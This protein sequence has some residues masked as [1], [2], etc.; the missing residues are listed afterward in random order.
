MLT[1]QTLPNSKRGT[2]RRAT[3]GP[4]VPITSARQ[5]P[6]QTTLD[7]ARIAVRGS[8]LG[9]DLSSQTLE[10]ARRSAEAKYLKNIRFEQLDTQSHR[11]DADLFDV[12]IS[13]AG[14]MFFG[15]PDAAFTNIAHA[16]RP[17]GRL[18]LLVWQPLAEN[19]WIRE[20]RAAFAVGR[21]LPMPPPDAPG[22]FSLSDPMRVEQ[23]LCAAGFTKPQFE[24]IAEPMSFGNDVDG[25]FD[26]ICGM[27]GWMLDNLVPDDRDRALANLRTTLGNHQSDNGVTFGS[28]TWFI[29]TERD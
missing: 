11:F 14:A 2:A 27:S 9:V 19:E 15:D 25:A 24:S 4:S 18:T 1:R 10:I 8:A 21:D 20:I 12:A 17:G 22:P 13:H 26:F 7:A 16:L 6:G 5:C 23:I 28:S 29:T 3:T